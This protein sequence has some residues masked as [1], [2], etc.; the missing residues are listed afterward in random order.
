M[1]FSYTR[2]TISISLCI[3]L[4][5]QAS[6]VKEFMHVWRRGKHVNNRIFYFFICYKTSPSKSLYDPNKKKKLLQLSTK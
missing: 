5:E 6:K 3:I 4:A 1:V 2:E